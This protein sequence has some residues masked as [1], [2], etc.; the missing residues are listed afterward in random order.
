MRTAFIVVGPTQT[1]RLGERKERK[2]G[3]KSCH[4]RTTTY[5]PPYW[6]RHHLTMREI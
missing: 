1:F 3:K 5:A 4:R 2:K 6:K